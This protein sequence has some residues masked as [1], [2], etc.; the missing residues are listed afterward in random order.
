MI[1]LKPYQMHQAFNL[2]F[3]SEYDYFKYGG[4]TRSNAD[5]FKK[6]QFKWQYAS[7][8]KKYDNLFLLFY[9]AYKEV[10]FQ[11]IRPQQLFKLIHS[12]II[13]KRSL[14]ET[15]RN[16][17]VDCKKSLETILSTSSTISSLYPKEYQLYVDE[18]V[19]IESI[20]L[21]DHY[22][23]K[24]FTKENSEDIIQW[25][26]VIKHMENIKPFVLSII[27]KLE[28]VDLISEINNVARNK[29]A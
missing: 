14:D 17:L 29:G 22:I 9:L 7:L 28:F 3:T 2:H 13:S 25:P 27:T 4:K 19:T 8:E 18:K 23:K 26:A 21:Y 12:R 20:I 1:G 16:I 24:V 5:S 6:N 15:Y 10:D 11:Y